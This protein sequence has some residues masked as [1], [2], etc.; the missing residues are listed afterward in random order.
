[1]V[2]AYSGPH[3]TPTVLRQA[4]GAFP[5]GVIALCGL[6]AGEPSGLACSSFNSVSLEP[7]LV[8][9]CIA[10]T[11][12]TWPG[13]REAT[14]LGVSVLTASQVEVA[15]KLSAKGIDRFEGVS[16]TVSPDGAV[17][18][19][20]AALWIDCAIRD[21]VDAGDHVIVLLDVNALTA[22]SDAAPMIF[23]RS[24]FRTL[25]SAV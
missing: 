1:M 4:F 3:L 21:E 18:I 14:R 6:I 24:A 8:S 15:R 19:D 23:H 9:V 10:K 7:P 13:L 25:V 2:Q 17:F 22:G 12:A 20:G 11:S 5:T 16:W